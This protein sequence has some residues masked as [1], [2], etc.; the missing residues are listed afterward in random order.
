MVAGRRAPLMSA[1]C[2]RWRQKMALTVPIQSA[3]KKTKKQK[4]CTKG[5]QETV[6]ARRHDEGPS[7]SQPL[8]LSASQP[9]SVSSTT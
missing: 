1:D 8:S 7:A 2:R 4:P 3:H 5:R 6:N 9:L